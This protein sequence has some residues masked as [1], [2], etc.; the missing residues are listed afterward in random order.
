MN[1]L[2]LI[3]KSAITLNIQS[4]LDDDSL[5]DVSNGDQETILNNNFE[6]KR[7]FEF[8]KL[9]LSE[10]SSIKPRIDKTNLTTKDK[11]IFLHQLA[12]I[13]KL[14]AV[15]NQYGYVKY[16]ITSGYIM[17]DEDG[18]YTFIYQQIPSTATLEDTIECATLGVGEDVLVCGLN[19]YYCLAKGMF[20]EYNVYKAQYDDGRARVKDMKVFAMPCRRWH[21]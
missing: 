4:V 17:F 5:E 19:A 1:I 16:E 21:E 18:T 7:L 2:D 15:K 11:R 13:G 12:G 6:L 10:V 14:L 3:K 20:A 8:A 9:V